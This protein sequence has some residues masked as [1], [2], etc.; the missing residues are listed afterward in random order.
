MLK[1]IKEFFLGKPVVPA[2]APANTTAP[3]KVPEPAATTPIPLVVETAPVVVEPAPVAIPVAGL[4]LP[5]E[6]APVA[7]KPK[8][9]TAPKKPERGFLL[10]EFHPGVIA[11]VLYLCLVFVIIW[12]TTGPIVGPMLCQQCML[13]A[14]VPRQPIHVAHDRTELIHCA[15]YSIGD[16]QST[17]DILCLFFQHCYQFHDTIILLLGIHP[18]MID[19]YVLLFGNRH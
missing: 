2:E 5:V 1:A 3:Y 8:K 16:I 15:M 6:A 11:H 12:R 18:G 10:G 19:H 17:F 9:P 4:M 14:F 13:F 7:A